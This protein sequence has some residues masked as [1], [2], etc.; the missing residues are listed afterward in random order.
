[1]I[2]LYWVARSTADPSVATESDVR[3]APAGLLR[4]PGRNDSNSDFRP[5]GTDRR[6]WSA[7]VRT[8]RT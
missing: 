4:N 8:E 5:H 6:T 7:P 2:L 3:R 1:V